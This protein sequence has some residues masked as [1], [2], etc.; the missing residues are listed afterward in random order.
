MSGIM[1]RIVVPAK[2]VLRLRERWIQVVLRTPIPRGGGED[3][4]LSKE[5]SESNPQPATPAEK[6]TVGEEEEEEARVLVQEEREE[7]QAGR[8]EADVLWQ[9]V[10]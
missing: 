7:E 6:R 9:E 8:Q 5:M 1:F 10:C 4:L 2:M 3:M